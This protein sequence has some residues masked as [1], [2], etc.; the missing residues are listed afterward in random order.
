M[1]DVRVLIGRDDIDYLYGSFYCLIDA[2]NLGLDCRNLSDLSFNL[3]LKFLEEYRGGVTMLANDPV[4][5]PILSRFSNIQK[6]FTPRE[7]SIM[8]L[9]L[10]SVPNSIR[11][12]VGALCGVRLKE[13][14]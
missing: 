9:R 7:S 4:P 13:D 3:L 6:F 11:E 8:E 10:H 14:E 2:P 12:K 1:S 5:A